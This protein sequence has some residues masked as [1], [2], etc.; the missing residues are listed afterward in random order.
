ML[1]EKYIEEYLELLKTTNKDNLNKVKI[2][3]SSK[4]NLKKI[5]TD[6]EIFLSSKG[7]VPELIVTKPTRTISGVAVIAIMTKPFKCPHGTCIYCPGGL[8][9][10]FG[11]VPQSYTGHEPS[12]MRGIRNYYDAYLQVMNRLEQYVVIG[13][14]PEKVELIIMG[15]TFTAFPK[16]Y[17]INFIRDSFQAMNDFSNLFY[18]NGVLNLFK[19]KEFFD[20]PGQRDDKE[21]LAKIHE[22]LYALKEKNQKDLDSVKN[23]NMDATIRCIG[24]TIE[25]KPDYGF[26]EHG[27]L[28]LDL[29]CTRV[30]LGI[31]TV[32][33]DILKKINR[34]HNL[35]D[36]KKSIKELRNLGFKLNFHLMPGLPGVTEDMDRKALK[37]IFDSQ[38]FKPDM[39]KIYPTMVFNKTGLSKLYNEGK[40]KPLSTEIAS[41]MIAEFL[42]NTPRYCRVMRVQRDIPTKLSLNQNL[43]NNLRQYIDQMI[44]KSGKKCQD[45]RA[46][47]I[48]IKLRDSVIENIDPKLNVLEYDASDGKEF[49][50]SIDDEKSD[51]LLGFCRLRFPS[52]FLRKEINEKSALIRELHVYGTAIGLGKKGNVQHKGFGKQLMEK[53]EEICKVNNKNKLVVISGIGVRRYYEK[54]GYKLEGP[55]M[56]KQIGKD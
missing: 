21:R 34:G 13:Q 49:F 47:E 23:D 46:R 31:Q 17:Q 20:L 48:G 40:Y 5:P 4:Y 1:P 55:Y 12:T 45:I 3:L 41:S 10:E 26:L 30:E 11:D 15:G 18:E 2:K 53:A 22:K 39:V 50:I 52:Q 6:I 27:N 24:L 32:Y 51:S 16:D 44:E 38:D 37:T 56:V 42:L 7:D 35:E 25:T 43:K 36:S 9:S 19:F 14:N 54:L 28:M 8:N 33:D 29:G